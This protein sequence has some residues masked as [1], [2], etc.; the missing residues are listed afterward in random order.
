M[1]STQ[2]SAIWDR[3]SESRIFRFTVDANALS[4]LLLFSINEA[5]RLV[6]GREAFGATASVWLLYGGDGDSNSVFG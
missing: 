1:A 2:A 3:D 6:E 4:D 5:L